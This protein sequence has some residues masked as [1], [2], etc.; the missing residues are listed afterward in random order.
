MIIYKISIICIFL[1][2][3]SNFYFHFGFA[4]FSFALDSSI[5]KTNYAINTYNYLPYSQFNN[6]SNHKSNYINTTQINYPINISSNKGH[7]EL[8]KIAVLG[9][10]VY[11]I[12]LDDTL[13]NR[14]IFF[15]RSIDG[16]KTFEKTINLSNMTG[17]AFDHQIAIMDNY[18]FVVWEQ[19]PNSNGQIF[20]KRSIDGGK[21]LKKLLTWATIQDSLEFLK[22]L[23]S[24]DI[25]GNTNRT[26]INVYVVW[27]DSSNGIVLRKSNDTGNTFD[28]TISLSNNYS[29]SFN[30]K[31]S[32]QGNNVY[33]T[34]I[35]I[36]NAKHRKPDSGNSLY[37]KSK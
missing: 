26:A 17:G 37:K 29:L 20:F 2:V 24:K 11:V 14:D 7:S 12:W 21:T 10:N 25:V 22:Y 1:F 34:W 8:P 4:F 5:K 6:N 18:V 3:S 16:G 28:K 15:K 31:I 27:H 35:S 33:S 13:G 9:T 19:S 23:I 32:S 30:P 36:H